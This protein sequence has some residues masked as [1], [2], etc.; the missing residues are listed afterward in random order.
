M[1][2]PDFEKYRQMA[3]GLDMTDQEK[4]ELILAIWTIVGVFVDQAF[5]IP[6]LRLRKHESKNS[7]LTQ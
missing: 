7:D 4:D 2:L 3:T 6:P 1:T 5:G